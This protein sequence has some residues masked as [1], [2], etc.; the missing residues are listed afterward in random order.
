[1]SYSY[2]AMHKSSFLSLLELGKDKA[3]FTPRF[4]AVAAFDL[5]EAICVIV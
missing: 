2:F 3:F 1:M 5:T 4:E